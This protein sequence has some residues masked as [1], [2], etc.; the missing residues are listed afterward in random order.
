MSYPTVAKL[1]PYFNMPFKICVP[2]FCFITGY[3]YYFNS[4]KSFRYSIKKITDLLIY[5]WGVFFT[6]AIIAI[7]CVKYKYTPIT[8][9][10]EM[11]ALSRPTM[12]FC[13]YVFFYYLFMLIMPLLPRV[14]SKNAVWN[15]ILYFVILPF[16]L[17]LLNRYVVDETISE[18]LTALYN[19]FPCVL[20]GYLFANYGWFEKLEEFN[21]KYIKKRWINIIV[22]IL[23][24]GSAFMCR[25]LVATMYISLS[26][27]QLIN[28]IP[29]VAISLD[30]LYAPIFIYCI[31]KLSGSFKLK[32]CKKVLSAIGDKSMLMWFVS[33]IFFNNCKKVFQPILYFPKKAIITLVW[34]LLICYIASLILEIGIKRIVK[35]KNKLSFFRR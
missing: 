25:F 18:L 35:L 5:Y 28:Y 33:C 31:I 34:G 8:F 23:V 29:S 7:A 12:I 17:N 22:W 21:M 11:F 3:A 16:F 32:Y 13:W 30:V 24:A 15:F 4:D 14:L 26:K 20:I 27:I 10:R 19:W 6:F 9:I 1:A 2:M